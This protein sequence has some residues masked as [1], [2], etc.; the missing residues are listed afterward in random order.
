M[1]VRRKRHAGSI[2]KWMKGTDNGWGLKKISE[3]I[4]GRNES[5]VEDEEEH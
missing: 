5:A 3:N 1:Q 4:T 2:G